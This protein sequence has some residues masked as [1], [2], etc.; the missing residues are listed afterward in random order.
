MNMPLAATAA[1]AMAL[2]VGAAFAAPVTIRN[3]TG[4][5]VDVQIRDGGAPGGEGAVA[6]A[7][8]GYRVA[9][10]LG[11]PV[12]A[13]AF[14][15]PPR[16]AIDLRL[17]AGAAVFGAGWGLAGF[18]PGPALASL[19][20]G[21]PGAWVFVAAMAAGMFLARLVPESAKKG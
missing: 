14:Q 21:A 12:L 4:A 6:V 19:G 9:F 2:M 13:E 7:F 8:A 1:L 20:L 16:A 11:K 17:A 15:L 10:G 18:C 3:C 5:P